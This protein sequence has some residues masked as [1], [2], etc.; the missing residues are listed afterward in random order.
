MRAGVSEAH[1]EEVRRSVLVFRVTIVAI[2]ERGAGPW[3]GIR[4]HTS[5]DWPRSSLLP[6]IHFS[7]VR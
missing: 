7:W 5:G 4:T 6:R 3:F 2:K 1:A